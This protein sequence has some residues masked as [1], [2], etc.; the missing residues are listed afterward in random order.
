MERFAKIVNGWK[1]LT[2]LIKRSILDIWQGSVYA[3]ESTDSLQPVQ[4]RVA[5][6]TETS[7]LVLYRNKSIDFI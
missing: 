5:F 1:P 3:P 6:Y 4:P 2:I 7:Q